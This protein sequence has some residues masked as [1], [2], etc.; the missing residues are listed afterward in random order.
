MKKSEKLPKKKSAKKE[1][2]HLSH[3]PMEL[4]AIIADDVKLFIDVLGVNQYQ[5]RVLYCKTADGQDYESF[6][7]AIIG[8]TTSVDRRYLMADIRI[9]PYFVDQWVNKNVNLSDVHEMVAHEVAHIA[10][11]HMWKLL[12]APFKDE[13]E[14]RDAWESLTTNIGRLMTRIKSEEDLTKAK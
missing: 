1:V 3:V 7:G 4:R 12:V 14:A 8:A 11:D 2:D 5:V 10:T 6:Q 13:G 9:Y